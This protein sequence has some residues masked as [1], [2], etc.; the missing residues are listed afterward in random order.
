M[1][2]TIKKLTKYLDVNRT[3]AISY[4]PD[5]DYMRSHE[6]SF[7]GFEIQAALNSLTEFENRSEDELEDLFSEYMEIYGNL[8]IRKPAYGEYD[9][10][11][12]VFGE[13]AIGG[14][15]DCSGLMRNFIASWI[16]LNLETF[17]SLSKEQ[18]L[19]DKIIF[20]VH[21]LCQSHPEIKYQPNQCLTNIEY[22]TN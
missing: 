7:T 8:K 10:D 3:Y 6:I 2:K 12:V 13:C 5:H 21:N 16:A 4:I 20:C 19:N 9:F 11:K 18:S 15:S 14:C 17:D 1:K 22:L